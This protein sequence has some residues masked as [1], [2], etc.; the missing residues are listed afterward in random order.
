M[1]TGQHILNGRMHIAGGVS[2]QLSRKRLSEEA[3]NMDRC[4]YSFATPLEAGT[5]SQIFD[6]PGG[7]ANWS[8]TALRQHAHRGWSL[9]MSWF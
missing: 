8:Y 7:D 9:C 1:R 3:T 2:A 6:V 4:Y 5:R